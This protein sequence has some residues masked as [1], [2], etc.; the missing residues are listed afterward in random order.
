MM[1]AKVYF[2]QLSD[3]QIRTINHGGEGWNSA[4]G[5]EYLEA[6]DGKLPNSD[7]YRLAVEV[8]ADNAEIVWKG[9]QNVTQSWTEMPFDDRLWITT[10]H[11]DK[12]RSMDVGDK[13]VW[14]DGTVEIVANMGFKTIEGKV[15]DQPIGKR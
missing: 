2:I 4:I 12:P 3:R 7:L 6:R 9:L 10:I 5:R 8:E 1:K 11:T 13:I 14:E 15:H